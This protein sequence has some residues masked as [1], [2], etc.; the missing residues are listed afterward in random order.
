L[1]ISKGDLGIDEKIIFGCILR[2][3]VVAVWTEFIRFRMR[4]SGGFL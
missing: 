1:E 3:Q 4:L 2:K